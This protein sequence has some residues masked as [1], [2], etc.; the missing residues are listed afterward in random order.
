MFADHAID[1]YMTRLDQPA[2]RSPITNMTPRK[3]II[4]RLRTGHS[5]D[6]Y[7]NGEKANGL[8]FSLFHWALL[9][10]LG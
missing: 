9:I 5:C 6:R 10:R 1:V 4:E 8:P 7:G 2:H 3:K